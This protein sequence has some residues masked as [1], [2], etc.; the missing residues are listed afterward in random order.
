MKVC[1]RLVFT[2]GLAILVFPGS[3]FGQ[4]VDAAARVAVL[5]EQVVRGVEKF[6][7][8]EMG[9]PPQPEIRHL[10]DAACSML[11]LGEGPKEAESYLRLALSYQNM[12][13]SSPDYGKLMWQAGHPE[14]KDDNS[15][16]F[17]MNTFAPAV[18]RYGDKLSEQFWTQL[19]PHLQA[20]LVAIRRHQVKVSY[21]NIYLMKLANLVMLGEILHDPAAIA[22]GKADLETWLDFTRSNGISEYDSPTY[23]AIQLVDLEDIYLAPPDAETKARVKVALDY[24]WS[25]VAANYFAGRECLGGP[26][27]RS[28]EFLYQ[29]GTLQNHYYLEGVAP[30]PIGNDHLGGVWL[31]A[32][33]PDD[34]H[35]APAILDLARIPER[36]TVQR[37][38]TDA[39][40]DRYNYITPD[41]AIGSASAWYGPQDL[42]VCAEF[43]SAKKLPAVAVVADAFDAP[44]GLTKIADK[45]GHLKPKHLKALIAA[46]QEKG[47]ILEVCDLSGDLPHTRSKT[48]ATNIVLPVGVDALYLNGKKLSANRPFNLPADEKATVC[49]R[50]GN[51]AL[52]VRIFAADGCMGQPAEYAVKYDGNEAGAG[53]LV[54]YHYRGRPARQSQAPVRAGI[55][56]HME[57]CATKADFEA[58]MARVQ[59]VGIVEKETESE[60]SAAVDFGET[61]LS[62]GLDLKKGQIAFRKIDGQEVEPGVLTVNG[63]N[64]RDE[65]LGQPGAK[66]SA[67]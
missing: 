54:A 5:R 41:F 20:A 58:F 44:F 34:Y 6:K 53:R 7:K 47:T 61:H 24:L 67:N 46:V 45:S 25:D 37:F 29:D 36:I 64:L 66:S 38:G 17:T 62:A 21:T 26:V 39:G 13:A 22:E 42:A 51:A 35:P 12:D 27:S 10:A 8:T 31:N 3:L 57:H 1:L 48:I 23:S 30:A 9:T 19:T 63:R 40:Q 14:I 18:L 33:R 16:E 55:F 15:V 28:Y 65:I 43:V 49:L 60:W 4:A 50:E 2:A 32:S 11:A 59:A 56:M 52:A